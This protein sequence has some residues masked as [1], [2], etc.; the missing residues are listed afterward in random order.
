[1]VYLFIMSKLFILSKSLLLILVLD[2]TQEKTEKKPIRIGNG[3][4]LYNM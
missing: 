2:Q 1:M 3:I 4:F